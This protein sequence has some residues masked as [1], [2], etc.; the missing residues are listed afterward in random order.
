MIDDYK[1]F[2]HPSPTNRFLMFVGLILVLAF[3]RAGEEDY[4]MKKAAEKEY[5][6]AK[7]KKQ[8]RP[9]PAVIWSQRCERQG[10]RVLATQADGGIWKIKCVD[11]NVKG[12]RA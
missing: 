12:I 1:N 6:Q 9:E 4:Q 11:A 8:A 3:A 7:A 10:K 2:R 5:A